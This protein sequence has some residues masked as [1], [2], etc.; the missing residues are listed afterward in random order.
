MLTQQP[1]AK[2]IVVLCTPSPPNQCWQG[3]PKARRKKKYKSYTQ[4]TL[5]FGGVGRKPQLAKLQ[6]LLQGVV[7]Y[8][9]SFFLSATAKQAHGDAPFLLY[10]DDNSDWKDDV[11]FATTL[12]KSG[13]STIHGV[14]KK[15]TAQAK[16]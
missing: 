5:K 15:M 12:E 16:A 10:D 1:P 3:V 13:D 7:G 9:H 11:Q 8:P 6:L 4:T 2:V 14:Y